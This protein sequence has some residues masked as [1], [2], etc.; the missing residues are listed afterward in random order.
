MK[1]N[2]QDCSK[3]ADCLSKIE[4]AREYFQQGLKPGEVAQLMDEK[5]IDIGLL[6]LHLLDTKRLK[7]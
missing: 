1:K 2:L 5:L 6:Y 3:E 7:R 4:Q